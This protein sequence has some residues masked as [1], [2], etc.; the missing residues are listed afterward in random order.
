MTAKNQI[1][2][3]VLDPV[4]QRLRVRP[5]SRIFS[6]W[7]KFPKALREPGARYAVEELEAIRNFASWDARG[8]I[9]RVA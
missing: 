5:V 4:S 8:K 2:E 3:V 1:V 7:V 6:G 9:E